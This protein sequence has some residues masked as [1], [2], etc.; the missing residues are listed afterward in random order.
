MRPGRVPGAAMNTRSR[1]LLAEYHGCDEELLQDPDRLE[2]LLRRAAEEAGAT[3]VQCVFHRYSPQGVSGVVVIE[4]S[5]LSLHTWPEC[6]YAAADFYTC[7]DS[8]PE[9]AHALLRRSLGAT[10]SEVMELERGHRDR[11]HGIAVRTHRLEGE[12][13]EPHNEG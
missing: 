5:H 11:P 13:P 4:E 2:A 8:R 12:P 3:V 10:R 1:H 6:G 7:G 9:R